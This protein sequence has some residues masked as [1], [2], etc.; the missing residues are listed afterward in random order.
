MSGTLSREMAIP[1]VSMPAT[2]GSP[3]SPR[4]TTRVETSTIDA[5]TK[6]TT[7]GGMSAYSHGPIQGRRRG[8]RSP[9]RSNRCHT[10]AEVPRSLDVDP[11]DLQLLDRDKNL[12]SFR[13]RMEFDLPEAGVA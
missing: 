11:A 6:M 13:T 5:T 10:Y 2:S 3:V 7:G 4:S 8:R 1:T 9:S 12:G